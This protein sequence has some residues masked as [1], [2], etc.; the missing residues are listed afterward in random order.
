MAI[1]TDVG[2]IKTWISRILQHGTFSDASDDH[3]ETR[4]AAWRLFDVFALQ[5][6]RIYAPFNSIHTSYISATHRS[7]THRSAIEI[8]IAVATI[9]TPDRD[10]GN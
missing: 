1:R 2:K 8:G 10:T 6:L 9:F 3:M 7:A 5:P 4:D